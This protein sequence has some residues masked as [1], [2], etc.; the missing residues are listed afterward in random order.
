MVNIH[1][2]T[3]SDN[4]PTAHAPPGCIHATY[5]EYNTSE[6]KFLES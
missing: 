3:P 1:I 5:V 2:P 4:R 6:N